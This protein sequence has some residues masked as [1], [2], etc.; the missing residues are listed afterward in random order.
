MTDAA[1]QLD[2]TPPTVV[3]RTSAAPQNDPDPA[4]ALRQLYEH[5]RA[6]WAA[7]RLQK[8]TQGRSTRSCG[9]APPDPLW[10]RLV[11]FCLNRGIEPSSYIHWVF[12]TSLSACPPEP[13]QFLNPQLAEAYLAAARDFPAAV[14]VA[15]RVQQQTART[16][17]RLGQQPGKLS[18]HDVWAAVLLDE[19]L[20]LS[21]LFRCGLASAI[22][23]DR[24]DRIA[25]RYE[26]AAARQ[27]LRCPRVYDAVWGKWVPQRLRASIAQTV[28][29]PK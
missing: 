1:R 23:G 13:I 28:L 24:F 2:A 29:P 14:T 7:R 26:T 10:D 20:P 8:A 4:T 3:T 17:I 16:H 15:L 6:A 18:P 21:A 12:D 22:G 9:L 25:G 5:E 19:T 11:T 27:Y